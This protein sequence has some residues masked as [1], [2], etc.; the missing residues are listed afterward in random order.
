[1]GTIIHTNEEIEH[2]LG[3]KR[4]DLIGNNVSVMMPRAVGDSHDRFIQ[5]Y[6]ETARSK[7]I[8]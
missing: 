6:F 3:F 7:I 8:D 5:R 2:L 1:M 4:K